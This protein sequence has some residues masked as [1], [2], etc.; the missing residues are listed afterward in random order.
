MKKIAFAAMAIMLLATAVVFFALQ[1]ASIRQA[2]GNNPLKETLG[3]AKW[4]KI[5]DHAAKKSIIATDAAE[6]EQT[7]AYFNE[8]T[9]AREVDEDEIPELGIATVIYCLSPQGEFPSILVNIMPDDEVMIVRSL[10]R[11]EIY[12]MPDY[13][14]AVRRLCKNRGLELSETGAPP[15]FP[16]LNT[17]ETLKEG[18]AESQST[19]VWQR[20]VN[21]CA[22]CAIKE[23]Y[24]NP[25]ADFCNMPDFM[26]VSKIDR[27]SAGFC[28]D[29]NACGKSRGNRRQYGRSQK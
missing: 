23:S 2:L 26:R 20:C 18:A 10:I 28:G 4:I 19:S 25:C 3:K 14:D 13:C 27:V 12:K 16:E 17:E 24:E 11:T 9:D 6:I 7:L 5:I 21:A 8:W 22:T 15:F 29:E 1:R